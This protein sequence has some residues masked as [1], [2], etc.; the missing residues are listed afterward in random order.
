LDT[1][2]SWRAA[3]S[4]WASEELRAVRAEWSSANRWILMRRLVL[5]T[6][7]VWG[8]AAD[9]AERPWRGA[10]A[11]VVIVALLARFTW[12]SAALLLVVAAAN[13]V[14]AGVIAVPVIAYGAGRR[15]ASLRR[16]GAVFTLA[17]A[18]LALKVL[19]SV[20]PG[21]SDAEPWGFALL[22][23]TAFAGVGLILPGTIGALTG[24][25][26]RRSEALRERNA[27]LERAQTL[28]DEQARMQERARIAGEMHDLLGHRLSLISLH[29]GAL[30]L[31]TRQSAPELS[32]QAAVMRTTAKTALDELR[33]VL[34]ILKVDSHPKDTDGHGDDAGTRAD[35]SALVLASQRAGADVQLRWTG[36]D[37]TGLDGTIRRALHRVVREALTNAHKH[38]AAATTQVV[39]ERGAEQIRVEV[40]NGLGTPGAR[41]APGTSMG[42]VGLRER[43][44]LAGGTIHAGADGERTEFVV[45]AL[46]PLV[47]AATLPGDVDRADTTIGQTDLA[48]RQTARSTSVAE[49]G[50]LNGS[51]HTGSTKTM[52]KPTKTMLFVLLGV[53]AVCC[54]GGVIGL[55]VFERK[56]AEGS[57]SPETYKRVQVGQPEDQVRKAVGAKGSI[58]KDSLT[59]DEPPIPAGATCLYAYSSEPSRDNS[60]SV[61]RFCMAGGKLVQK[62]EIQQGRS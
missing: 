21:S 59:G 44:R 4:A 39:V 53:V 32:E 12:P 20:V 7:V 29:A 57:I 18:T 5:P 8:T 1:G 31:R 27:I 14:A 52:S 48:G 46:L 30:E 10:A 40:R 3:V 37:T 38:A 24:E 19:M 16:A 22:L 41:T 33:E 62:R 56:V 54:G 35:V 43:V 45:S 11:L 47:P 6:L 61:Y 34:G 13:T 17:S 42:L 26:A 23:A 15:I 60:R 50:S 28:G 36:D 55:K 51:P 2:P 49:T 58:A 25:R 9:I